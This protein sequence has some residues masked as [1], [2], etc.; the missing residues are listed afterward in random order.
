M[1]KNNK[2][3]ELFKRDVSV[4]EQ[5]DGENYSPPKEYNPYYLAVSNKF[6]LAKIITV[7]VLCVFVLSSLF[8]YGEDF[9]YQNARYVLRDL[10]QILSEDSTAPSERLSFDADGEMDFGIYRGNII[11][12]GESGVRILSVTGKEKLSDSTSFTCPTVLTSD[13]YCIVYSLGAYNLSVYNTVAR[14]YD[15]KFDYPIYDVALSDT[16]HI[17]VMTQSREYRCVVYLYDSDFKLTAT[18]NKTKYPSSVDL[19]EGGENIYISVFGT[20]NGDY[21]TQLSS[22]TAKSAEPVYSLDVTGSLPFEVKAMDAG[23]AAL[24]MQ[25]RLLFA[26]SVGNI[27]EDKKISSK[28]SMCYLDREVIAVMTSDKNSQVICCDSQGKEISSSHH[29]DVTG[30][31]QFDS[32]LFLQKKNSLTYTDSGTDTVLELQSGAVKLLYNDGYVFV[33]YTDAIQTINCKAK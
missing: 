25:D 20:N 13:K 7:F 28:I 31:Y 16:G 18:Y 24:V 2:K 26:D 3:I 21:I 19:S 8:I 32:K 27:I 9:T 30:I 12:A 10:G 14:V 15:M 4:I 1:K 33:C 6:R 11:I 22:Y 23:I 29:S 17:A 5:S